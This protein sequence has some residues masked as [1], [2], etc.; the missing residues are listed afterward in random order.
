MLMSLQELYNFYAAPNYCSCQRL[1]HENPEC[2]YSEFFVRAPDDFR[3]FPYT[4][5]HIRKRLVANESYWKALDEKVYGHYN[6]TNVIEDEEPVIEFVVEKS[7]VDESV[8]EKS[9]VVE[10]VV[11][12]SFVDDEVICEGKILKS[13]LDDKD[14]DYLHVRSINS[15]FFS[16]EVEGCGVFSSLSF[17][18]SYYL[19]FSL[20]TP[21]FFFVGINVLAIKPY[22][23][24]NEMFAGAFDKLLKALN[25]SD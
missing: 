7:L 8:I 16:E 6:N 5:D 18:C 4:Y 1:C 10:T 11:D 21:N 23:V 25:S 20:C 14:N 12:N 19:E 17:N 22:I 9:L 24:L 13:L 3:V 15:K 2:P